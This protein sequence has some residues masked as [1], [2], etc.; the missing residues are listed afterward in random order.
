MENAKLIAEMTNLLSHDS[1]YFILLGFNVLP[2]ICF[3]KK[4][5][6]LLKRLLHMLRVTSK[7]S[8]KQIN[9]LSFLLCLLLC[10]SSLN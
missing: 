2:L 3:K 4:K 8:G 1:L 5:Y 10:S 7:H 6:E 9:K